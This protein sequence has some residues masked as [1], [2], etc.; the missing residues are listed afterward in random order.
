MIQ[1]LVKYKDFNKIITKYINN[2]IIIMIYKNDYLN[3]NVKDSFINMS[4]SFSNKGVYFFEI[5]IDNNTDLI[6]LLDITSYP[7]FRIYMKDK[8]INEILAIDTK[9]IAILQYSLNNY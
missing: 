5:D 2:S 8:L 1:K 9:S 4:K 7:V 3:H 6:N